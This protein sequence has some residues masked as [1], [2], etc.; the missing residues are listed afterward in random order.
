VA[1]LPDYIPISPMTLVCPRC[2]AK[3]R[4][5]CV[6][7]KDQ[8]EAIHMERVEAAVLKDVVAKKE[9]LRRTS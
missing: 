3:P 6:M 8:F 1:K 2:Q 5:A 4:Q 7:Y 9:R